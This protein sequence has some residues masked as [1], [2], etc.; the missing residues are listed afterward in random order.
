MIVAIYK[1]EVQNIY[2][3]VIQD[4]NNCDTIPNPF[5]FNGD[6]DPRVRIV[7]RNNFRSIRTCQHQIRVRDTYTGQLYDLTPQII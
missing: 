1:R 3:V 6:S 7:N 4:N 5:D 2:C